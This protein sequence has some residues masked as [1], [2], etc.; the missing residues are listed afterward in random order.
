MRSST[1]APPTALTVPSASSTAAMRSSAGNSS[2][3]AKPSC[4][5]RNR[6]P[7][8]T[9]TWSSTPHPIRR[10][11]GI[12][13]RGYPRG[14]GDLSVVSGG[15]DRGRCG[16]G[17][18]S[19]RTALVGGDGTR[20]SRGAN[21]SRGAHP[22][23]SGIHSSAGT[24]RCAAGPT[25]AGPV[26]RV[27]DRAQ[28]RA[29]HA[30]I[31]G[32]WL[33]PRAR[34]RARARGLIRDQ[35]LARVDEDPP[36]GYVARLRIELERLLRVEIDDVRAAAVEQDHQPVIVEER[37]PVDRERLVGPPVL[38]PVVDAVDRREARAGEPRHF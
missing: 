18:R 5:M 24:A 29:A 26:D 33:T 13:A 20:D 11:T 22:A 30:E 21:G 16:R 25:I 9:A 15:S 14:R 35:R 38:A 27:S 2:C 37:E 6:G 1:Y 12:V 3:V 8:P 10:V 28:A 36:R 23:S 17:Y 19:R 31:A 4:A 34:S 7:R 32:R